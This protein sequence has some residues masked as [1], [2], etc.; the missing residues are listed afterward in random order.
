MRKM[1]NDRG[2][3]LIILVITVI[4]LLI[5]TSV[6]IN[7]AKNQIGLKEANNLYSDLDILTTKVTDYYLRKK[8]LPVLSNLYLSDNN[9]LEFLN[10]VFV[11]IK[12]INVN[13]G[14]KYYVIDLAKLDNL[15]LH[16]GKDYY[17]WT[18]NSTANNDILH[19]EDNND[20]IYIIN[21]KT[22][23][24][25]YPK[26]VRKATEYII[27]NTA[28]NTQIN[29]NEV[30]ASINKQ[31]VNHDFWWVQDAN[32]KVVSQENNETKVLINTK[33]NFDYFF[34][35]YKENSLEF[36][37]SYESNEANLDNNKFVKF[38]LDENDSAILTSNTI[39]VQSNKKTIYLWIK[40]QD[41]YGNIIVQKGDD[42]SL[43]TSNQIWEQNGV[44]VTDNTGIKLEVGSQVT[45]YS[46]TVSGTT[47]GDGKWYV[48]GAQSGKL[49]ITTN[50]NVTSVTLSG[51]NG[52]TSGISQLNSAVDDEF[53]N[54]S[55]AAGKAR[56]INVYDIN[57]VTGYN[58]AVAKYNNG[59]HVDQFGNKVTYTKNESSISYIGTKYPT[60]STITTSYS[61]FTYWTGA[62]WEIL[63]EG[64]SS[65]SI[66][67]TFYYYYP[68]TL[69]RTESTDTSINGSSIAYGLLFANTSSSGTYY[70]LSSQYIYTNGGNVDFGFR[71]IHSGRVH[72]N[73][74]YQSSR[75]Y[76][77]SKLWRTTSSCFKTFG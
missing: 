35:I 67:H 5:L 33:I 36:Q 53:K 9:L 7:T 32:L 68:Q 3:T 66:K 21:E 24:I 42:I 43:D 2:I 34:P 6:N 12:W 37:Y 23:Q 28:N 26:G 46:V 76:A 1:K 31:V 49:L 65:S 41:I 20:D 57:R 54:S 13:D 22:H 55:L 72:G 51:Q 58:P 29:K 69:T 74:M 16:Y 10:N 70:W 59:N 27:T 75:K 38:S 39:T 48:L 17:K 62:G 40:V 50:E 15:T 61:T 11:N 8:E 77:N 44:W 4:V 14:D 45:G 52:F 30:E 18:A 73:Y 71:N 56:S 25:Y 47:Y 19:P 64:N 63:N 60:T